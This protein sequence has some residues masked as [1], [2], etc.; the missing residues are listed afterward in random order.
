MRVSPHP[1]VAPYVSE[2]E[3][4]EQEEADA[5]PDEDASVSVVTPEFKAAG[6]ISAQTVRLIL[7]D[8]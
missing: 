3:T 4:I 5:G 7:L 1:P 2:T 8:C 6:S